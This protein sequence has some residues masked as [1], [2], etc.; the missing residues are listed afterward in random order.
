MATT[1]VKFCIPRWNGQ[2]RIQSVLLVRTWGSA[3]RKA[4]SHMAIREGVF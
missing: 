1:D 3:P 4:G 2:N